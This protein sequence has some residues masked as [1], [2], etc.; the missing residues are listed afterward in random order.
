V[1]IFL[2]ISWVL[3]LKAKIL[4]LLGKNF[5]PCVWE[6]DAVFEAIVYGWY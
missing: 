5:L 4:F 1:V 6:N 3:V 2:E